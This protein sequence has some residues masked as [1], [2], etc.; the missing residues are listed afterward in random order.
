V[1]YAGVLLLPVDFLASIFVFTF[2]YPVMIAPFSDP[3]IQV[4]FLSFPFWLPFQVF[5]L[6]LGDL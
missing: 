2:F 3:L 4:F 1:L 6:A 5:F